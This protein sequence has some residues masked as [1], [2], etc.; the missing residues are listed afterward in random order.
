MNGL[1]DRKLFLMPNAIGQRWNALPQKIS[2]RS[3]FRTIL[4]KQIVQKDY[5]CGHL[6]DPVGFLIE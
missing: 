6:S 3:C 5:C 2:D 4:R 1:A